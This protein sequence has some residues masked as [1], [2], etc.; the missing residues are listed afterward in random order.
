MIILRTNLMKSL[1]VK[2]LLPA[3]AGLL[4]LL[5]LVCSV[6][7]IPARP[8]TSDALS[9]V[10]DRI[11]TLI[12]SRANA[13]GFSCAGE[14]VCG[15]RL[16]PEFYGRRN[17]QPVWTS[18]TGILP[19]AN[20]LVLA[21]RNAY[22][23]GL[24]PSDYHLSAIEHLIGAHDLKLQLGIETDPQVRAELDILLT[25]A[26]L[27]M[28]SHLYGGRVNPETIHSE[29]VAFQYDKDLTLVLDDA[30]ENNGVLSALSGLG[31][32]HVGYAA[33]QK[34]LAFYREI[35]D[36]GGWSEVPE[37]PSLRPG[38]EAEAVAALRKRLW[39]TGDLKAI[40]HYNPYLFDAPLEAAVRHFQQRHGLKSDG[41]VGNH[42]R[43]LL[44]VP[45]ERR[46]RQLEINM[47]R[48]RWVPHELGERYLLVNIADFRLT[49]MERGRPFS[50]MRVIVGRPYRKTPVF[51]SKMTYLVF[52]PYWNVPYKLAV[53]DI[54]P[55]IQ[56]DPEFVR[57]QGF[58]VFSGWAE[59]AAEI[60][61]ATVDW[62][63]FSEH[64]FPYRLRQNP[65][66][67]NALG[68]VK[69]MFPNKFAVYLHDT[70]SRRL[71]EAPARGYSS[72][73]IRVE[74]PELLADYLLDD[75]DGW[76]SEA[77]HKVIERGEQRV[78]RLKNPMDV[79]ILYWTAWVD[80][81]GVV[82]FRDDVYDRDPPL[83]KALDERWPVS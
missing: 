31:P 71:F 38:D 66:R 62:T 13:A 9:D 73:C 82:H 15:I 3:L 41:I 53:E 50:Q 58:H 11:R 39:V 79:H 74:H 61:P 44:N 19:Q 23:Q 28:G 42:T 18:S 48:W 52:N 75:E 72:G 77:I 7:A 46:V 10:P 59:D 16:L 1:N 29:W 81:L 69:F 49:V 33:I 78:V 65:G 68:R 8:G 76:D 17:Y 27:L 35:A 80:D 14:M 36:S 26:F 37:G 63:G 32:P 30:L 47:E 24:R 64:S 22:Q 67:H 56:K 40:Q 60:D 70:P 4:S 45:V 34:A 25:D 2:S 43:V 83:A 12:A 57:N 20:E 5:A 6:W 51:S 55:K 54:L 21:I